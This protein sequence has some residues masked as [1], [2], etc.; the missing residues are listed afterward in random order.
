MEILFRNPGATEDLELDYDDWKLTRYLDAHRATKFSVNCHRRVPILPYAKVT[1][2]DCG[3]IL[4]RG[5]AATRGIVN[6][7]LSLECSGDEEL[8]LHRF[9]GRAHYFPDVTRLVHPFQSAAPPQTADSYGVTW[10]CGLLFAANSLI[11]P[12]IWDLEDQASWTWKLTGGGSASR[13]GTADIYALSG[14][15]AKKLTARSTLALCKANDW[16]SYRDAND[17]Y[18]QISPMDEAYFGNILA[19]NC[20]DTN[21]RMGTIDNPETTLQNMQM[22]DNNI[23]ECLLSLGNFFEQPCRFR[24]ATDGYTYLDSLEDD[25]SADATIDLP[26]DQ[27]SQ[28]EYGESSDRYVHGLTGLGVGSRDPR[29]RYTKMDLAY[30]G[31]W[32]HEVYDVDDGFGLYGDTGGL[33]LG[34]T[35]DEYARIR[36]NSSWKVTTLPSFQPQVD[37]GNYVNLRLLDENGILEQLHKLRIE[38]ITYSQSGAMAFELGRRLDDIIDSFNPADALSDVYMYEYLEELYGGSGLSLSGDIVL[39]DS[40]H[41]IC[42]GFSGSITLPAD[43]DDSGNNHRVTLDISITVTEATT[44][45]IGPANVYLVLKG[46]QSPYHVF[47]HY[48]IGDSITGIDVTAKMNYGSATTVAVYCQYQGNW[49]PS[50]SACSGHPKATCNLTFHCYKRHSV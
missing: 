3:K 25:G 14:V 27:C 11:P 35:D 12:T 8:L 21:V 31:I 24:Y 50:H 44:H 36:A 45:I 16:S 48:M 49:L 26:E 47:K 32:Y 37:P 40:V 17:L 43:I 46:S 28:V 18:I 2:K 4:F 1:A 7:S 30:Q 9:T 41:G 10:N 29:H 34:M 5:Y 33:L 20:F 19:E 13:L 6:K 23:M 38:S 15:V 39:G 42:A 22:A